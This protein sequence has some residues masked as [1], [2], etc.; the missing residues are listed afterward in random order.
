MRLTTISFD[1][2]YNIS[3]LTLGLHPAN[4]RQ[5]YSN[6]ISHWLGANL[7]SA[8]DNL[9]FGVH[10]WHMNQKQVL[11]VGTSNY[12]TQY[13]WNVITCPCPWY[14]LVRSIRIRLVFQRLYIWM[15]NMI[16][17]FA[18][19]SSDFLWYFKH[20]T[21]EGNFVGSHDGRALWG[22]W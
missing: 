1:S 10:W 4:E 6:D 9:L 13:L 8:L 21:L 16:S 7:E 15:L 2:V 11:R 3:R 20:V 12:I 22:L 17:S 18:K 5:H 14:L 19:Y